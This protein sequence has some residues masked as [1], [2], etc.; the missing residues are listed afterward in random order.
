M[1]GLNKSV[2][3]RL[4]LTLAVSTILLTAVAVLAELCLEASNESRKDLY[5]F[6]MKKQQTM[7]AITTDLFQA[8][9][10]VLAA[11]GYRDEARFDRAE[12]VIQEMETNTRAAW[13][14]YLA[15]AEASD[16][17]VPLKQDMQSNLDQ[18]WGAYGKVI[19]LM[20]AGDFD[21][22]TDIGNNVVSPAYRGFVEASDAMA[23]QDDI[24]IKA[25]YE[26][27]Q[28]DYVF[29]SRLIFGA[30]ALALVL[31][32]VMGVW[33]VRSILKPL[34]QAQDIAAAIE[35]GDLT[36]SITIKREDEFGQLLNVMKGM[37]ARLVSIVNGVRESTQSVHSAVSEISNGNDDLSSRTQ[38]QAASLE[39]TAASMEEMTSTVRQNSD[40][41][42]SMSTLVEQMNNQAREGGE[43]IGRTR[44]AMNEINDSSARIEDI[45]GLI[46]S[47]AFQTNLLALNASVEAA[48]AGE[49]GRGFAVVAS[50][51]RN[52][53]TRSAT[54]AQDIRGLVAQNVEKAKSGVVLVGQSEKTLEELLAS[55]HQVNSLVGEINHA[56]RE[57]ASG[58]EQVNL[59]I[60]QMDGVTQ[61][62][63]ALV[64][65]SA[66]AG[67]SL[68]EQAD[69]LIRQVA[70][71]RTHQH[72]VPQGRVVP[73][74]VSESVSP[75]P[76]AST[77]TRKPAPVRAAAPAKTSSKSSPQPVAAGDDDWETF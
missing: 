17:P 23:A 39:E 69:Q 77:G 6:E 61:Q 3:I 20:R 11:Y 34:A 42:D 66:A 53:A 15:L 27:G 26:A 40:S 75:R 1:L 55:A 33:L 73:A 70:V 12:Q 58:I 68:R 44:K 60:S 7:G 36:R 67:H 13:Q 18:F 71:F 30:I 62:N 59:A 10:A 29:L 43:A 57:Q 4:V 14:R 51:V 46:D 72:D 25:D 2:K 49:Q 45:I 35:Q 65:Q 8:R 50:E 5:E 22:A 37:Q 38:E 31:S 63:A 19:G 24:S 47:I 16:R 32:A 76:S 52:L 28:E 56:T 74:P 64:E 48:R 21:Q 9:I 41:M 54:A